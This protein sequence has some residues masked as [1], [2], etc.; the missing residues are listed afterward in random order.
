MV[1]KRRSALRPSQK[2][3]ARNHHRRSV[4]PCPHP[5]AGSG[6]RRRKKT[7]QCRE[8]S[9]DSANRTR[10]GAEAAQ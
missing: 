4:V 10:R 3:G 5:G 7:G 9:T 6:G 1:G 2:P 8:A